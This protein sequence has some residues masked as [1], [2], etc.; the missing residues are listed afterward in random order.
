MT[1]LEEEANVIKRVFKD[2]YKAIDKDGINKVYR[3]ARV[4]NRY[5]HFLANACSY[6]KYKYINNKFKEYR[7]EA[8]QAIGA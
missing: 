1:I 5:H 7:K 3:Q 6:E 4:W 8:I 2:M